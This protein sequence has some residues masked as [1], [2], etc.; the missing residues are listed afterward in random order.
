MMSIQQAAG[1]GL[2]SCYV[3]LHNRVIFILD[4]GPIS[5]PAY[6]SWRVGV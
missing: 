4:T 1:V 6:D 3:S 2:V 5:L